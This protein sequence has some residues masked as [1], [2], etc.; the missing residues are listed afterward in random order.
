MKSCSSLLARAHSLRAVV[1]A[2]T[3]ALV[4]AL[5]RAQS[6]SFGP[7]TAESFE[8]HRYTLGAVAGTSL[9]NGQDG[10]ILFDSIALGNP[11]LSAATVQTA[12]VRSG[13]QAVKFDAAL[14]SPGCFG[15]LRRNAQFS[16]TTGVIESEMDFL[17]TSSSNPS[18]AWEFY[19]QAYPM[20]QS[21]QFRWWIAANGRV[22]FATTPGF[23]IVQTNHF[24]AKDAWHHARTVVDPFGNAT[25]VYI[26]GVLVASGQPISS[27]AI[28]DHGFSQINVLVAG[29]DAFYLDNFTVRERVAPHGLSVDLRRLP[30]NRRSVME[31]RLAGGAL[32]GNRVY[33]LLGS[34]SGTSPGTPLG[35]VVLPLNFDGFCGLILDNLAALPGFLA[36]FNQDGS[37]QASFDTVIAVPPWLLGLDLDWAYVTLSPVDAVSEPVR[38]RVTS[39]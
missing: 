14:M 7:F 12:L 8:A 3:L 10:W 36:P 32:L 2:C 22:E 21:C 25:S 31:F 16:L 6:G 9:W 23:V 35:A 33:A 37:S 39:L 26:D 30:I 13:L 19:T 20:P 15:E 27:F 4:A 29:N 38:V 17:I 11:N 5:A 24:V 28:P 1:P 18:D 34:I